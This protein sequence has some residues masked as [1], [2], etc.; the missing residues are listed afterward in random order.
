MSME[1]YYNQTP[2][3]MQS[4]FK[5]ADAVS[6][7]F[8]FPAILIGLF[9]I[10][11]I[12]SV[13]AGYDAMKSALSSLFIMNIVGYLFVAFE[14]LEMGWMVIPTVAMIGVAL[15]VMLDKRG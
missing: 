13:M 8:L 3:D 14:I 11:F 15:F 5:I 6:D 7:N 4:L 10:L 1:L 9:L 2:S 12:N